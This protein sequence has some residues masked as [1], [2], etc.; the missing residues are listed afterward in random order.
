MLAGAGTGLT[1]C[2]RAPPAVQ[3]QRLH[4]PG[5]VQHVL[6]SGRAEAS[7]GSRHAP[8]PGVRPTRH[9]LQQVQS[10]PGARATC[11]SSHAPLPARRSNAFPDTF[12]PTWFRANE[13]EPFRVHEFDLLQAFRATEALANGSTPVRRRPRVPR[14]HARA[15][16]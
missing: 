13:R 14:L 16:R 10:H 6:V 2:G 5:L 15:P 8:Q 7:A 4:V 11:P 3:G 12:K 1:G 9:A